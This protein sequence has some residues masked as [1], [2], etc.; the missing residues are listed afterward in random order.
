M[1]KQRELVL[2]LATS[3]LESADTWCPVHERQFYEVPLQGIS[4]I[5]VSDLG[6][7]LFCPRC[8]DAETSGPS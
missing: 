3:D 6:S 1:A 7:L 8:I 5:G 4:S 2:H